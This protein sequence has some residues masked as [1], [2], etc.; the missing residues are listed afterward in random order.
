MKTKS[1]LRS[2]D[3]LI[4]RQSSKHYLLLKVSII[5][6]DHKPFSVYSDMVKLS[7]GGFLYSC[8]IYA[9]YSSSSLEK[10]RGKLSP[11]DWTRFFEV[12][13]QQILFIN[14][15]NHLQ[16]WQLTFIFFLKN[17][18]NLLSSSVLRWK[19]SNQVVKC[20]TFFANL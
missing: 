7:S 6:I 10:C 9:S 2:I 3:Y 13:Q 1:L 5:L 18:L 15:E 11:D 20:F 16:S 14:L 17:I 8:T 12:Q 19:S 4:F